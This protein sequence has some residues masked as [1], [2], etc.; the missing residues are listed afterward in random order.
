VLCAVDALAG[1]APSA[2]PLAPVGRT[3]PVQMTSDAVVAKKAKIVDEVKAHMAD[4]AM[5][6][7]ARSEGIKVNDLNA[8]R[9]KLP[10]SVTMRCVKNTLV[11]RAAEDFPQFQGGDDMLEYSNYWFF[12]PE[13]QMRPAVDTWTEFVKSSNA[14]GNDIV[15]GMFEGQVLDKAGVVAITKLPTKQELMGSTA[16]MLKKLPAKLAQSI[17]AAG[18]GRLARVTKQASGQKLVQAVK[19]MEGKKE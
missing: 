1:F 2:R 4:S 8:V 7:C 13:D 6:F 19:A 9:Q 10:E 12:V 5:L 3:S 16:I 14:E 17:N 11:K 15:G 18:A